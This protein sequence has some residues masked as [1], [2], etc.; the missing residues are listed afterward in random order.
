[1][2]GSCNLYIVLC[3]LVIQ[4]F[5]PQRSSGKGCFL[6]LSGVSALTPG[7]AGVELVCVVQETATNHWKRLSS[8]C[9]L[10]HPDPLSLGW[11]HPFQWWSLP[12]SHNP[13]WKHSLRSTN[14]L[15]ASQ[16]NYS[17]WQDSASQYLIVCIL[18]WWLLSSSNLELPCLLWCAFKA[19]DY[20]G[21]QG[22]QTTLHSILLDT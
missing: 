16:F 19:R 20:S 17:D 2:T 9:L 21:F 22:V 14:I 11:L 10:F 18:R 13:S 8:F 6:T 7:R 12:T 4:W 3:T 5:L 1:M 15:N